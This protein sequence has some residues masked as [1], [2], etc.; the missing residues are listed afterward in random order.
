MSKDPSASD[1]MEMH[2][3]RGQPAMLGRFGV[4][5]LGG[6]LEAINIIDSMPQLENHFLPQ[7]LRS[8]DELEQSCDINMRETSTKLHSHLK[9]IFPT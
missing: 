9:R 6:L 4:I 7:Q 3:A 5:E 8:V 1:E 2:I